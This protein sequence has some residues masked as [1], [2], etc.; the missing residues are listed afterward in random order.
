MAIEQIIS[1]N[2]EIKFP[3]MQFFIGII[4]LKFIFETYV[5]IR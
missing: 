5:N 2:V 4:I 3:Y 1:E